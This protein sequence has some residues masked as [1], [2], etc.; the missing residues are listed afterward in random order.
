[1]NAKVLPGRQLLLV[2][3]FFVLCNATLANATTIEF[4]PQTVVAGPG[5]T[6]ALDIYAT[7]LDGEIVSAYD[8]D[9]TY[10]SLILSAIGVTFATA[11]G[12]AFFFEV[13]EAVDVSVPGLV[14]LAQ[15]SLL[16][17]DLLFA[18]QG[19]SE[20]LLATVLFDTLAAGTSSLDFVFDAFNDVKGF[21]AA[22]LPVTGT[23]G[24]VI[25]EVPVTISEPPSWALLLIGLGCLAAR[26]RIRDRKRI[27]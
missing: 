25:V 7:E 13:L 18:I 10:D 19:G 14:D 8:F 24:R 12:D 16:P 5:E 23:A 26:R 1:M 17:D 3:T 9:I 2:G 11:L 6:I 22:I 21:D 4:R 27:V 15:L 20:V